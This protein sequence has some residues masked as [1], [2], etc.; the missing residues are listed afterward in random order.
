MIK[1]AFQ[2]SRVKMDYLINDVGTTGKPS[3]KK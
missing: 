3:G 1:S 2:I